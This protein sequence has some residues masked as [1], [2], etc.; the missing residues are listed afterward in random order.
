VENNE[1]IGAVQYFGNRYN[2]NLV[3]LLK[4]MDPKQKCFTAAVLT[5]LMVS[6]HNGQEAMENALNSQ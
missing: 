5:A 2:N 4:S 1:I 3:W 6:A